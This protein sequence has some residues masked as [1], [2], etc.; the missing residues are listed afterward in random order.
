MIDYF[1][2]LL[3]LQLAVPI[4]TY[5]V[6]NLKAKKLS[7]S[8]SSIII[9]KSIVELTTLQIYEQMLIKQYPL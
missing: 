9:L 2:L 8:K 4:H 3:F 5:S 7:T 1:S 6:A